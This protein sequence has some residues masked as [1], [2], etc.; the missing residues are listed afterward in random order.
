M[1]LT[2][3]F[4]P[5]QAVL[6]FG[7]HRTWR[8]ML[9]VDDLRARWHCLG[10]AL[11]VGTDGF[12]RFQESGYQS[13]TILLVLDQV[14]KLLASH[15]AAVISVTG[16]TRATLVS[17]IAPYLGPEHLLWVFCPSNQIRNA[18]LGDA[19]FVDNLAVCMKGEPIPDSTYVGATDLYIVGS[20]G[21]DRLAEVALWNARGRVGSTMIVMETDSVTRSLLYQ[22]G[23]GGNV[24]LSPARSYVAVKYHA[25]GPSLEGLLKSWS[26]VLERTTTN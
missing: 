1:V 24:L 4:L 7:Q 21:P 13:Q 25:E 14:E 16:A 5:Y 23:V 20:S 11:S 12:S 15:P 9:L 19:F 6:T 18:V 17:R 3:P 2:D 26:A 22:M 10:E 8:Y